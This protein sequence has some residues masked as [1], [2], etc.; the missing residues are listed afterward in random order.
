MNWIGRL[1]S[2][3]TCLFGL[4]TWTSEAE[5][6][7]YDFDSIKDEVAEN[8]MQV[9]DRLTTMYCSDCGKTFTP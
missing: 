4:H 3:L 7:G 1:F 2:R 5:Q 6:L 8:P 9:W